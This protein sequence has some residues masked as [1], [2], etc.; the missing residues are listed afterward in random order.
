[1]RSGTNTR[2]GTAYCFFRNQSLSARDRYATFNP[3][4]YRHQAGISLGGPIRKDKLFY[5]ANVEIMRRDFPLIS[6]IVNPQFFSGTTYIGACGAP[7]TPA[8][9]AAVDKYLK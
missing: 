7:A 5:F 6:S 1:A 3:D 8:P 9:G 4:E 2:R